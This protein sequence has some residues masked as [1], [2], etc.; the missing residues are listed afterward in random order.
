MLI[1]IFNTFHISFTV[2][3]E[4]SMNFHGYFKKSIDN[5]RV[6]IVNIMQR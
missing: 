2:I 5:F 1:H 3:N 4:N 6:L